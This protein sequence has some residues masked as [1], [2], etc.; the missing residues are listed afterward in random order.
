MS[1]LD[2]AKR[3]ALLSVVLASSTLIPVHCINAH[4]GGFIIQLQDDRLVIGQDAETPGGQP[5]WSTQAVGSLFAPLQYSDLPSFLSLASAPAGTQPLPTNTNIYWDFLPMTVSGYTSN[6]LYWNGQGDV[7]FGPVPIPTGAT[8]VTMGIYN[9]TDST[10]ALVSDT[11]DM[12]EGAL[13]GVTNSSGS[14]LRLHRH[15]YFLLDDGDG[16][17]PTNVAEGVYLVAL[18]LD[19]PGYGITEPIFVV[20]GT[21]G[22]VSTS[23]PTLETAVGWVEQNAGMLILDGDYNFDGRVDGADH[24]TW[25]TQF[26]STGPFPINGDFADGNRDGT[27]DAA[28]YVIWRKNAATP[29]GA[30]SSISADG[31]VTRT[32][33]EPSAFLLLALAAGTLF[34]TWKRR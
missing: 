27:V 14:G 24:A 29:V 5:N 28:D 13:L 7:N 18:Q 15:N 22:L 25:R 1:M 34:L 20:P 4:F 9:T 11:P 19:M 8:D 33:P 16:V 6:L 17:A 2:R 23:L 21:Y 31:G 32:V 10:Q 26:G 30:A 3:I 12:V